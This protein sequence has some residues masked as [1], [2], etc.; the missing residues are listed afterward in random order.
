MMR[1]IASLNAGS[2]SIK[3]GVF[4]IG[5]LGLRRIVHGKV[6]GIGIA[7]HFVVRGSRGDRLIDRTWPGGAGLEHEELL[8]QLVD[9]AVEHLQH[10]EVVAVGHRV[11][12]GGAEFQRPQLVDDALLDALERLTRIAPLHQPHNLAAI[13]ALRTLMPHLPQVACFDTEF[14][15]S[16]P[17]VA[18]QYAVPIEW[19]E[20]GV[21][22]HGFHGLSYEHIAATLAAT[23]PFL[24]RGR[25][26]AA[27]LGN[28]ASL[29]AFVDGRSVDTTM[30][31]SVLDGLV[32]GSRCGSLDPAIIL[33]M[34]RE[35]GLSAE[36]VQAV[37]YRESGLL[38]V[39][40]LSSDM[41]VLQAS[42][43]PRALDAIELFVWRIVREIGA[44]VSVMGG[45]DTLVFT[46]G[47][48]ENDSRVRRAICDRLGWLGLRL[49]PLANDR[50]E[51]VINA[52]DSTV[53]IRLIPADEERMIALHCDRLLALS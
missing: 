40:G 7:P 19:Q 32:M 42:G 12:H 15:T 44:L 47:I 45:I 3:F 46:G 14:H 43:D 11:L 34:I 8:S 20:K 22:S 10:V 17:A 9:Y 52:S 30:G 37:L 28:G 51:R 24:A 18:K 21:R 36:Q 6:E 50:N 13:R 2:S 4:V 39:S 25:V 33:Y 1:A 48:G 41:R 31:F 35:E 5:P 49:D 16:R 29:C 38:G 23:E 53:A 26:L 27:H